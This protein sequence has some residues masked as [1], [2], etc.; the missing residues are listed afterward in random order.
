[1]ISAINVLDCTNGFMQVQF[2]HRTF[3]NPFFHCVFLNQH[4][5]ESLFVLGNVKLTV[6]SS[7]TKIG[8]Q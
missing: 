6:D 7:A 4:G 5:Y 8:L 3:F 2:R 1:M